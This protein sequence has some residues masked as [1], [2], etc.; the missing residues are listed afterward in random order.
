MPRQVRAAWECRSGRT[1]KA[2]KDIGFVRECPITPA[3]RRQCVARQPLS[4]VE[5]AP[6]V[7]L[8]LLASEGRR[9]DVKGSILTFVSCQPT[10]GAEP[11]NAAIGSSGRS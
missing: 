10:G 1:L 11:S 6:L 9:N 4:R 2:A 3:P 5:F 8:V 7:R